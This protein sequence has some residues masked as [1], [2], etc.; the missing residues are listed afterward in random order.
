MEAPEKI[1]L[2]QNTTT[3]CYEEFY[4]EWFETR[5][6]K[7]DVEYIRKDVV[8][9]KVR[10]FIKERFY[11][12]DSWHVEGETSILNKVIGDFKKYMKV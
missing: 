9:G 7:S 3:D 8:I 10:E 5:A 4:P 11:F 6:R 2:Q 12:E 1:Y